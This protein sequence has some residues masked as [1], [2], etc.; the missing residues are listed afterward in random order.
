MEVFKSARMGHLELVL[1][2][3]DVYYIKVCTVSTA[4]S[5][6]PEPTSPCP[7]WCPG[8][9]KLPQHGPALVLKMCGIHNKSLGAGDGSVVLAEDQ[10]PQPVTHSCL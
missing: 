8:P 7:S 2:D 1:D 6:L 10:H 9:T 4:A 5:A 3:R